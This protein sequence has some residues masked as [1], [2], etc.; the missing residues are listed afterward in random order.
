M[1]TISHHWWLSKSINQLINQLTNQLINQSTT[2]PINQSSTKQHLPHLRCHSA[3]SPH[4]WEH[5]GTQNG[6]GHPE[7]IFGEKKKYEPNGTQAFL[8]RGPV[9]Q[10]LEGIKQSSM[11]QRN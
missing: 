4:F 2:Q 10:C 1:A 5:C 6:A 8:L 11:H 7:Q 3:P 9:P